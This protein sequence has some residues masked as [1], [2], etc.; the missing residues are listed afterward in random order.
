[1]EGKQLLLIAALFWCATFSSASARDFVVRIFRFRLAVHTNV[2]RYICTAIRLTAKRHAFVLR[3]SPLRDSRAPYSQ[4]LLKA[5]HTAICTTIL[6]RGSLI[7]VKW[8]EA[9]MNDLQTKQT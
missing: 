3:F 2:Q 4:T 7:P 1:M 5:V 8:Q 9:A 6:Q